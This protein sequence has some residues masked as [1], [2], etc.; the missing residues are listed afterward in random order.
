MNIRNTTR[1]SKEAYY[2]LNKTLSSKI[3]IACIVFTKRWNHYS[4][5]ACIPICSI[6]DYEWSNKK[7]L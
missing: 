3:Y 5:D 7:K 4:N 6:C 1:F 2:A